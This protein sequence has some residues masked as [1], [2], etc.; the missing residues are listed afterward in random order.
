MTGTKSLKCM[1]YFLFVL[2]LA[3]AKLFSKR[4][5]P[6][7]VDDP[8]HNPMARALKLAMGKPGVVIDVG[9]N[10]GEQTQQGVDAGRKVI[11]IECLRK[12]YNE[13]VAMFHLN[14]NVTLLHACAGGRPGMGALHL[15]DDSSS[16]IATNVQLGPEKKKTLKMYNKIHG[17]EDVLIIPLDILLPGTSVALLKV[18]TQGN[19]YSVFSGA[20]SII[21]RERPIIMFENATRFASQGDVLGF[22]VELAYTCPWRFI[23]G[24]K[25]LPAGRPSGGRDLDIVCTPA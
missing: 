5:R 25:A 13:L 11:A 2:M 17:T 14:R 4:A 20:R 9:A 19:E 8:V 18:D 21:Q 10:G 7:P 12:A 22:L 15:A 23:D 3:D 16:M 1:C 24:G 6:D